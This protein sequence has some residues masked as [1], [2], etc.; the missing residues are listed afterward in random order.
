[1]RGFAHLIGSLLNRELKFINRINTNMSLIVSIDRCIDLDPPP[2]PMLIQF[3]NTERSL[4]E[5]LESSIVATPMRPFSRALT[6]AVLWTPSPPPPRCFS[7]LVPRGEFGS[8]LWAKCALGGSCCG[9]AHLIGTLFSR[10]LEADN[11]SNTD[12]L[13]QPRNHINDLFLSFPRTVP[14]VP[15]TG[16]PCVT[17]LALCASG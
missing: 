3:D 16:G 12:E 17:L 8:T 5:N 15:G 4:P 10:K 11:T 2:L 7:K 9:F 1:M 14:G 13:K 6:T